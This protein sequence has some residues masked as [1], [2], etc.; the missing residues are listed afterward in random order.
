MKCGEAMLMAGKIKAGLKQ[1]DFEPA[2]LGK[3]GWLYKR[4]AL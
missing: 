4:V 2:F 3:N 1:S